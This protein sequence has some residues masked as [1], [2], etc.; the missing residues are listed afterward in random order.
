MH[1][2]APRSSLP[3]QASQ[4]S[5]RLLLVRGR[6]PMSAILQAAADTVPLWR[7]SAVALLAVLVLGCLTFVAAAWGEE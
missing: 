5:A 4:G 6:V 1:L 7:P 2:P 3:P